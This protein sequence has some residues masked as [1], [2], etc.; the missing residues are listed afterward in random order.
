MDDGMVTV[1][2]L[3]RSMPRVCGHHGLEKA[4]NLPATTQMSCPSPSLNAMSADVAH[5]LTEDPTEAPSDVGLGPSGQNDDKVVQLLSLL[6]SGEAECNDTSRQTMCKQSLEDYRKSCVFEDP[7][8]CFAPNKYVYAQTVQPEATP[9]KGEEKE[10]S[11]FSTAPFSLHFSPDFALRISSYLQKSPPPLEERGTRLVYQPMEVLGPA[12]SPSPSYTASSEWSAREPPVKHIAPIA[13]LAPIMPASAPLKMNPRI[14]PRRVGPKPEEPEPAFIL[15][16]VMQSPMT[17]AVADDEEEDFPLGSESTLDARV[18]KAAQHEQ[19]IETFNID[20]FTLESFDTS[21]P[22]LSVELMPPVQKKTGKGWQN[23]GLFLSSK[24]NKVVP[25][26]DSSRNMTDVEP[27]NSLHFNPE[28]DELTSFPLTANHH[29]WIAQLAQRSGNQVFDTDMDKLVMLTEEDHIAQIDS[30]SK[31]SSTPS[32]FSYKLA[33]LVWNSTHTRNE[34]NQYCYC[35]GGYVDP[36]QASYAR[37]QAKTTTSVSLPEHVLP[38]LNC[39]SC[40]QLFHQECVGVIPATARMEFGDDAYVFKCSVCRNGTEF[41]QRSGKL[42]WPVIT[43]LAVYNL[44]LQNHHRGIAYFRNRRDICIYIESNAKAY[45]E[46]R[47]LSATWHSTVSAQLTTNKDVFQSGLSQFQDKKGYWGLTRNALLSIASDRH[48]IPDTNNCFGETESTS[49]LA[50][51][52]TV[53]DVVWAKSDNYPWWPAQVSAIDDH[54]CKVV[55]FPDQQE[56]TMPRRFVMPFMKHFEALSKTMI[57]AL[58]EEDALTFKR[59]IS[60]ASLMLRV[61]GEFSGS[62]AEQQ[63]S[64]ISVLGHAAQAQLDDELHTLPGFAVGEKCLSA[65]SFSR[66]MKTHEDKIWTKHMVENGKD[67]TN[68]LLSN[69]AMH[70]W[71]SELDHAPPP[72]NC[73][74]CGRETRTIPGM[75]HHVRLVHENLP[76]ST[77][78]E[79][80]VNVHEKPATQMTDD[81]IVKWLEL[82]DRGVPPFPCISCDKRTN[83]VQGIKHHLTAVH[84]EIDW[85]SLQG[86]RKRKSRGMNDPFIEMNISHYDKANQIKQRIGG[87]DIPIAF[88]GADD[89]THHMKMMEVGNTCPFCKKV[90]DRP[91]ACGMHKKFCAYNPKPGLPTGDKYRKGLAGLILNDTTP[92]KRR[93]RINPNSRS[94]PSGSGPLSIVGRSVDIY[95]PS[96]NAWYRGRILEYD[97]HLQRHKIAYENSTTEW[98][99]LTKEK[100]NFHKS[101]GTVQTYVAEKILDVRQVQKNGTE[102]IEYLIKWKESE[103]NG[104]LS[105]S[106][107]PEINIVSPALIASFYTQ[108]SSSA[109]FL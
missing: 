43:K 34:Q 85:H 76:P 3:P 19:D 74:I 80:P 48:D 59:S 65:A 32:T 75:K 89:P 57:T 4:K 104:Q 8:I 1:V 79:V 12:K 52:Y 62:I 70:Q 105:N 73:F 28:E 6:L 33:D 100:H 92:Q 93:K 53:G 44:T 55:F 25:F 7:R 15:S 40:N 2:D 21:P 27:D 106:W 54:V 96:D 23:H 24:G 77:V 84:P 99:D 10:D 67:S 60:Q 101:E 78:P 18:N 71:L 61:A 29:G 58:S 17:D 95:W 83:S 39:S 90:F 91:Q 109:Q 41:F 72:Y 11:L 98:I 42:S 88:S 31:L 38:M 36:L 9:P 16:P 20:G 50:D 45:L 94:G 47:E 102:S 35:G 22:P 86:G 13:T 51:P 30:R 87:A 56:L 5:D 103:T 64:G 81:A 46:G 37:I 69:A 108:R 82:L 66:A 26:V 63:M 107:E 14:L 97:A 49:E 68:S